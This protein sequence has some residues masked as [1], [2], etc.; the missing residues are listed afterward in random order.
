MP[1]RFWQ[2]LTEN[3]YKELLQMIQ[4]LYKDNTKL[5]RYSDNCN[6]IQFDTLEQYTKKL[7]CIF[8]D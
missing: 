2:N 3:R 7:M 5:A 1:K 4:M 6:R 8:E